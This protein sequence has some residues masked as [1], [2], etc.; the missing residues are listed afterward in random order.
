MPEANTDTTGSPR[1]K[2]KRLVPP[3]ILPK[4]MQAWVVSGIA[5]V[6]AAVIAFSGKNPPKERVTPPPPKEVPIDPNQAR[7]E[8]YKKR[9]EEQTRKL[10]LEQASEKASL[11]QASLEKTYRE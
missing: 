8:E 11:E 9:I 1:I 4:N 10:Q 3:G 2:D 6:M 7:I 5:L